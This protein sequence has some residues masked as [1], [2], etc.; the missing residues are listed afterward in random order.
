MKLKGVIF[1]DFVNYKLP[2]MVLEFPK[3][4]FKCDKECGIPI[5]QN[6]SL[7]NEPDIEVDTY[8]LVRRYVENPITHAVVAQGLEPFDS[9]SDLCSFIDVLRFAFHCSDPVIIYTGYNVD[10]I[11]RDL[12]ELEI[13][14]DN[15]IVKFGR[16]IPGHTPHYDSVL[17]VNLASDNQYA[18][19][20]S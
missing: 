13:L 10:E 1:E 4:T 9:Y 15:I 11:A 2:S 20:I 7:V 5:C 6:S 8:E 18:E 19:R 17:G 14:Y 16:F 3:C 12:E